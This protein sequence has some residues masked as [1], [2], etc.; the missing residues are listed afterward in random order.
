MPTEQEVFIKG[1]WKIKWE[2]Y[3]L[4]T[5]RLQGGIAIATKDIW[6]IRRITVNSSNLLTVEN[7]TSY[8]R[9][10]GHN[11]AIMYLG[12]FASW[13]QIQ[14]LKKVIQDNPN[15]TYLHFGD[16]DIGG[17]LIHKH[18]CRETSKNFRL[19][20]MGVSQ[21]RDKRFQNCLKKLTEHDLVR[22]EGFPEEDPY[23]EVLAYMKEFNVKL[24]QEIVSYY[25]ESEA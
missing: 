4:E 7:K 14:F 11:M 9:L 13:H 2:Q 25:L 22:L 20:C 1:D 6:S 3:I 5:D 15:I 18:L 23:R 10:K 17:F 24:E 21:L 19:F 16:I 12:G 8:Q